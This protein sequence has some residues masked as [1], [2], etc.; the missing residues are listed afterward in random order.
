MYS[1]WLI[2]SANDANDNPISKVGVYD[3]TN[4]T[5][6]H[7]S[8]GFYPSF[9]IIKSINQNSTNWVQVDSYRGAYENKSDNVGML[10]MNSDATATTGSTQV[11]FDGDGFNIEGS[12]AG[13]QLS[14]INQKYLYWA[15][16]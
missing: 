8:V 3:G 14:T 13:G 1:A 4:G 12:T 7:V 10:Y 5:D 2:A 9:V 6:I 15:V 11:F 16:K